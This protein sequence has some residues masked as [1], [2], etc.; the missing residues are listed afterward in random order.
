MEQGDVSFL[1]KQQSRLLCACYGVSA[2]QVGTLGYFL[3]SRLRWND[4]LGLARRGEASCFIRLKC[5]QHFSLTVS[6][7]PASYHLA[8]LNI[9]SNI[10]DRG[11]YY[12]RKTKGHNKVAEKRGILAVS[13]IGEDQ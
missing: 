7:R 3:D 12:L 10:T 8:G 9:G 1:R 11:N 2:G 13:T 5:Y 4:T 6:T